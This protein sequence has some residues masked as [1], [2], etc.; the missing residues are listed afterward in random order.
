MIEIT[1]EAY[2]QLYKRATEKN[3]F[4]F[5]IG[6]VGG[7]C[8]GYKYHFDYADKVYSNDL[9]IDW[10]KIRFR[11]DPESAPYL[12]G[13]TLD[14]IVDGLNEEFRFINPNAVYSCGCGESIAV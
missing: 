12:T 5:R 9:V 10:G 3:Q 13:L 2:T 8:G 7:G 14:Y 11:V 6:L 1:N 4:T